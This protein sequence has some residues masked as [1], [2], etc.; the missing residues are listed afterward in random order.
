MSATFSPA[1]TCAD[2]R[3]KVAKKVSGLFLVG[4]GIAFSTRLFRKI[5]LTP[6]YEK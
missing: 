1:V 5:N 3:K 2:S 6:F 4:G